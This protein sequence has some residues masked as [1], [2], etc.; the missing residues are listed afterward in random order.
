MQGVHTQQRFDDATVNSERLTSLN[1]VSVYNNCVCNYRSVDN[2]S[3][4][5]RYTTSSHLY[6]MIKL[7]NSS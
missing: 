2:I 5:K 1:Y 7:Y 4:S 6:F 3:S